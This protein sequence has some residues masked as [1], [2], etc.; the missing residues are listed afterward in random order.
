[1]TYKD[2]L[3][4]YPINSIHCRQTLALKP[5]PNVNKVSIWYGS[6]RMSLKRERCKVQMSIVQVTAL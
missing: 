5:N 2:T 6:A 1:M 4:S 3:K